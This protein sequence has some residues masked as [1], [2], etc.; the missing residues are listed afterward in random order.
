MHDRR[1]WTWLKSL[2]NRSNGCKC[3]PVQI[4]DH[5]NVIRAAFAW[6]HVN[7]K[8]SLKWE[9]YEPTP[10]T[11]EISVMRADCMT[12][13][14]CKQKAKTLENAPSKLYRGLAV[15]NVAAIRSSNMMVT[16]SRSEF[17]G[18]AHISTGAVAKKPEPNEPR[19]PSEVERVRAMA[20]QLRDL[21]CYY[22]DPD[23]DANVWPEALAL[24][25]LNRQ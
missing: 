5:Q 25:P 9:A 16:D 10:G 11:D 8:G 7:G 22:P 3:S 12:P 14:A 19:D 6:R 1:L 18:H 15:L 20:K 4:P 17:C 23:P 24:M 13:T 21:S 2:F